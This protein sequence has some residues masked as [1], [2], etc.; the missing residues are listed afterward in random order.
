MTILHSAAK[1]DTPDFV[2]T[3]SSTIVYAEDWNANHVTDTS[4]GFL[5]LAGTAGAIT[6]DAGLVYSSNKTMRIVGS[7]IMTSRV[8]ANDA[9]IVGGLSAANIYAP[10]FVGSSQT[11]GSATIGLITNT[12]GSVFWNISANTLNLSGQ[13]TLQTVVGSTLTMASATCTNLQVTTPKFMLGS[14]GGGTA[15]LGAN[16]PASTVSTPFIW[17]QAIA[18]DNSIIWIPAWK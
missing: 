11:M 10:T 6:A 5:F 17:I 16:T 7:E 13:A 2:F 4:A 1:T 14:A 3:T 18:P 12:S 15:L 9:S 8:T